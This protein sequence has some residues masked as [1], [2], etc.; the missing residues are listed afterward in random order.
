MKRILLYC[1]RTNSAGGPIIS[2]KDIQSVWLDHDSVINLE[3]PFIN[4]RFK[5]QPL[6]VD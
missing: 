1:L 6:F 5:S 3:P 4:Q 2:P